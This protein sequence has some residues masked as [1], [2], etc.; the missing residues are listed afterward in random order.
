MRCYCGILLISCLWV[1]SVYA[2]KESTGNL[3]HILRGSG[4]DD[5]A[6]EGADTADRKRKSSD[7]IELKVLKPKKP[8][9]KNSVSKKIKGKKPLAKKLLLVDQDAFKQKQRSKLAAA[10]CHY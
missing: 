7:R 4:N 5:S 1:G 2:N 8:P 3:N 6:S 10:Y 9:A